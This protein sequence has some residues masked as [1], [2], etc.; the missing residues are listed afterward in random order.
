MIKLEVKKITK[1]YKDKKV[2]DDINFHVEDG[3][4]VSILG[5]S[6]CGKSTLLRIIMGLTSTNEGNI[7]LN[8]NDVTNKKPSERK[9][10]MVFQNFALFPNMTVFENVEYALKFNKDTKERSKEIAIKTI[11]SVGLIEHMNKKPSKLS[12]GQQQRVAIARTLALNPEII[13]FDEPLSA[14]DASLRI[15]L[16]KEIKDLQKKFNTT[17]IYITHDQEEALS[18]SDRVMVMDESIIVQID[19]PSN[20]IKNPAN[21][22]VENFVVKNLKGKFDDLKSFMV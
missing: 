12:G 15:S 16:R 17:I 9:M 6:G 21:D 5:P 8:G 3:E 10:G 22:Y 1:K 2:L 19:T 11:E 20:I 7:Y 13:L 4:F 14:L 18:M